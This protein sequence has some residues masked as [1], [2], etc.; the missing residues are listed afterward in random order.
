MKNNYGL[1]FLLFGIL[2]LFTSMILS[3][4]I[5]K[6]L[7]QIFPDTGGKLGPIETTGDNEIQY[8]EVYQTIPNGQWSS[9]D[10]QLLD[11]KGTTLFSFSENLWFESGYDSDGY[12]EEGKRDFGIAITIPK[13]GQYFFN[14]TAQNSGQGVGNIIIKANRELGSMVGFMWIGI[15]FSLLGVLILYISAKRK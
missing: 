3:S 2:C 11:E 14:I 9:V 12:W 8:V 4:N 1:I 6:E 5:G 7:K 13:K 15:L 10:G